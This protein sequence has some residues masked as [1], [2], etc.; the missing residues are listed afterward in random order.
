MDDG[1]VRNDAY[2]ARIATQCFSR[3]EHELLQQYLK[4]AFDL[5]AEINIH[6]Q[7]KNQYSL[8]V[9]AREFHKLVNII[10]PYADEVPSMRYK[11]NEVLFF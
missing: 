4:K 10:N 3:E 5:N 1:S 6:L 7:E 9:P 11:L 2:S 8:I